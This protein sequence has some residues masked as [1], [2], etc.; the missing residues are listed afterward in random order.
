MRRNPRWKTYI[1]L[2][3]GLLLLTTAIALISRLWVITAIPI[4]FL[5][6]FF[7]QKGDLCGASAF[8]EVLLAKDWRK[9]Q[10]LWACIVV[11][12]I[13]FAVLDGLG[14]VTLNVK[15]MFWLN[16]VVGG[17]LF[18]SG[19]VLA[20][21]CVS[22]CLY[23]A[24][25]GNLNSIAA[26]L[27]MPFGMAMVEYGP[28]SG[29]FARMKTMVIRASDG[30][31][32]GLP[33]AT[34]IPYWV[35]AVVF[36]VGTLLVV[37]A[38]RPGARRARESPPDGRTIHRLLTRPW[39]PWKAGVAI[40]I[41]AAFAYV[42]SAASGRNYPLGVTHGVLH[43][44]QLIMESG[45]VQIYKPATKPPPSPVQKADRKPA[46]P[47]KKIVWWLVLLVMS[48]MLGSFVSGKL[49]G[50]ARLLPKPPDETLV[51]VMGGFLVGVGAV[52]ATGCVIGN[53]LSGWALM[54]LGML[55]FGVVTVLA[56]WITTYFY[57]MGAGGLRPTKGAA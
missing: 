31:P 21:G 12:M 30:S 38:K 28:L 34:G 49:S 50:Q 54:S 14:L 3:I 10:G 56:N 35:L 7:L 27:A 20:G 16:Y 46:K 57:L 6:G 29:L 26:L 41:L 8:S 48:Q 39:K 42:S 52:F 47:G 19:M 55:L 9:V 51:A 43:T 37:V 15:P 40:G 18:G 36:A 1:A 2:S 33:A 44:Q 24:A 25:T 32:L 23:K 53:I 5:F 17:L 11:S 4:G 13:G 22:G 45:S